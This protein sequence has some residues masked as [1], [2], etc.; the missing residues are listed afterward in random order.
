MKH[1]VLNTA[2]NDMHVIPTDTVYV[3][4]DKDAVR[5]SGMMMAS[6]TIPD[7]MVI[8][9]SGKRY[10]YKGD[11]MMLELISNAN[12]TRPIYVAMTVG[13]DNYMNL[14]DNFILEG[15]ANR[16]SP[17]T[18]KNTGKSFDTEKTYNNM[19]NRYRYGGM[20]TPGIYIDETVLRMCYTHR[21]LFARLALALISEGKNDKALKV[22]EKCNKELPDYNIPMEYMSGGNDIAKAY[23]LLGQKAKAKEILNKVW[24]IASQYATWYLGLDGKDFEMSQND[25]LTQLYIMKE[26]LNV[27]DIVD[28]SLAK[29]QEAILNN[30][31]NLYQSKGGQL[32]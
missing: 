7:K 30:Y 16:I 25:I 26:V 3:K 9:L 24:T 6:D 21:R 18:T 10:L 19:M 17:F 27:S 20:N 2:D 31:M 13:E 11:L 14:G 8:S 15:L 22:L 32:Q 29:K 12:W 28:P 1:W 4:I 5:K 23:A